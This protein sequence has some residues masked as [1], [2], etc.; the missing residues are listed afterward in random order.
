MVLPFLTALAPFAPLIG[1]AVSAVGQ[2][3]A[4]KPKEQVHKTENRINIQQL[5]DDAEAAGFNPL[6]IIRGGGLAGY[7]TST[8]TSPALPDMRLSNAF[9]TFGS[10]IAQWQFDPY[11]QR[12][13]E[14]EIALA[15]AQIAQWGRTGVGSGM[16]FQTPK[17]VGSHP[18]YADPEPI[19]RARLGL[20]GNVDPDPGMSNAQEVEDRYGDVASWVYG[21]GVGLADLLHWRWNAGKDRL[22]AVLSSGA[23]RTSQFDKDWQERRG[24]WALT[25]SG[26]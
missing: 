13:S 9:Q 12:R 20:A 22:S 18:G 1:G 15:E 7:G 24:S 11:S 2:L 21:I 17:A 10:G 23:E 26:L 8:S 3:L 4:P 6:T 16:T 5:R 19:V 14:A 25:G